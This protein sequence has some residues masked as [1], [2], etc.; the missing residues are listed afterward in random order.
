MP[1]HPG[2][3]GCVRVG[4]ERVWFMKPPVAGFP[5]GNL[6]GY[7]VTEH[8]DGSISVAEKIEMLLSDGRSWIG[9]LVEG[10]WN[11]LADSVLV[12]R[13]RKASRG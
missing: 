13:R 9:Y 12:R 6:S 7:D 8:K 3:Y 4:T 10:E 2:E 11:T 5:P 1:I